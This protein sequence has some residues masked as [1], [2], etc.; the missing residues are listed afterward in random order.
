MTHCGLGQWLLRL[1][2]GSLLIG[3]C[4]CAGNH[5]T[6]GWTF[7]PFGVSTD[8]VPGLTSPPERIAAMRKAAAEAAKKG[9]DE[10]ERVARELAG[11]LPQEIDPIIRLEIVRAMRGLQAPTGTST[12]RSALKDSDADVRVV[13]CK[14]WGKRGGPEAAALLSEVLLSDI[15]ADVR[16]AAVRALGQVGDRSAVDALGKSLDDRDPTMQYYAV[17]SLRRISGQDYGHDLNKW[18]Q[19]AKGETPASSQPLSIADRVRRIF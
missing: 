3:V 2:F 12:L 8:K 4:G 7:W 13:A 14:A 1:I 16:L 19:Y 9:P 10:Q 5:P 11:S 15:D 17:D 6:E 18:R